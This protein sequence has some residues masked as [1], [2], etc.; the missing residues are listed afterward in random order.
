MSSVML[1]YKRSSR[2]AELHQNSN[3]VFRLPSLSICEF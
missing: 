3:D 2:A 1:M